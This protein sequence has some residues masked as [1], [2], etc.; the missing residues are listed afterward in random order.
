MV[1]GLDPIKEI[2]FAP[3]DFPEGADHQRDGKRG[4]AD[5]ECVVCIEERHLLTIDGKQR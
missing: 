3:V 5:H 4:G 2:S 1:I